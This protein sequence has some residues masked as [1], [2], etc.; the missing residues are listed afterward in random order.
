MLHILDGSG[1][2]YITL[3]CLVLTILAIFLAG[4]FIGASSR[5]AKA[6]REQSNRNRV[7]PFTHRKET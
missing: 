3:I 6:L 4:Y 2:F 7:L 1:A 5:A